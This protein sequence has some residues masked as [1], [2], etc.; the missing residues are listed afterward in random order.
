LVGL[1]WRLGEI[2]FAGAKHFGADDVG[3]DSDSPDMG[4]FER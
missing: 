4:R 3:G 2:E 1:R